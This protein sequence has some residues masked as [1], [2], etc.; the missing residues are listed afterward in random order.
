[1]IDCLREGRKERITVDDWYEYAYRRLKVVGSQTPLKWG[2]QEEGPSFEI[3]NFRA[4][5]E[6]ERQRKREQLERERQL[7][8]EQLIATARVKLGV[9]VAAGVL[10][11]EQVE[12]IVHLLE[13]ND[14]RLF[15][16]ERMFRKGV[17]RFVKDEASFLEVF[18]T[19]HLLHPDPAPK[20]QVEANLPVMPP[21]A[22][23]VAPPVPPPEST[24]SERPI[25]LPE[26]AVFD[27]P[28]MPA[29]SSEAAVATLAA[30]AAVAP[31]VHRQCAKYR[32]G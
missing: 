9:L 1:L 25:S 28:V 5:H 7:E 18:G 21:D 31:P 23:A 14:A 15:P 11:G 20:P 3:A 26:S 24:V 17:T 12:S 32:W 6:R 30:S 27:E 4:K 19:G 29:E 16:H 13:C 22:P 10:M 2:L 8:R